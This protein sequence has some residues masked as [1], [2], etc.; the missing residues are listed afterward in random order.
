MTEAKRKALL[1]VLA[2]AVV[3]LATPV[4]ATARATK[5]MP[6]SFT[7]TG[8]GIVSSDWRDAGKS[9]N[10]L[11]TQEI[12]LVWA[13][14]FEGDSVMEVRLMFFNFGSSE[15]T[16]NYREIVTFTG[17]ILDEYEGSLT[18]VGGQGNWR[19]VAGTDDLSNLHG[20]GKMA[21]RAGSD[22]V[23]DFTGQVHFDP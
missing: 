11:V 13:G 7:S 16:Y 14:D 20:Q 8:A 9:D 19:I 5:P 6:V 1:T 23:W 17:V 10:R 12:N 15:Q 4:I 18:L 21:L 22:S 2:I 3:L